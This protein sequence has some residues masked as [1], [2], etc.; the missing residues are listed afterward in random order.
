MRKRSMEFG[1]LNG[2]GRIL[3]NQPGRGNPLDDVFASE[4]RDIA[5]HCAGN[6]EVRAVLLLAEGKHF[7]FGGDLKL[8]ASDRSIF[9]KTGSGLLSNL[10][11]GIETLARIDAPVICG[12]Q[13]SVA[14]GAVGLVAG[15]DIVVA[16]HDARFVPAFTTIGLC[17][18][19]GSSF[20]LTRKVG[21]GRAQSFHLLSET[22]SAETAMD[23]GLVNRIVSADELAEIAIATAEK[24]AAGPT[25]ALGETSRLLKAGM[26]TGL[27][28]QLRHE[29][30]AINQLLHTDD[31]WEGVTALLQK[32]PANFK[33]R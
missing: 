2:V 6:P 1:V 16:A 22:W 17:P 25:K 21:L 11:A 20:W 19:S 26:H 12:V 32:R 23:H 13:G 24:L 27:S 4:F 10:V 30:E 15:C 8:L 9:Q 7:S 14:G 3:L 18:D 31:A 28:E 33:G 5:E 29:A